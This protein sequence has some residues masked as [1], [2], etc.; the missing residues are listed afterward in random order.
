[1][2]ALFL[3]SL[4]GLAHGFSLSWPFTSF[5]GIEN[6]QSMPWLNLLSLAMM[7]YG[8]SNSSSVRQ[9]FVR[10]WTYATLMLL[11]TWWWLTISL[12]TY[13]GLA[14]VLTG[15]AVLI[16]A[17]GL[18]LIWASLLAFLARYAYFFQLNRW[19]QAIAFAAC[20]LL[21][22]IVRVYIFTGFPWGTSAY[23]FLDSP[24]SKS[25]P[26]I[27]VY[28]LSFW[29]ALCAALGMAGVMQLRWRQSSAPLS[30]EHGAWQPL[31]LIVIASSLLL[32]P[33][34]WTPTRFTQS[35]GWLSVNLLQ[36]NIAQ[37]LKFQENAGIPLALTWYR[38]QLIQNKADLVMAPETAIPVLPQRLPP[39]YFKEIR[40]HFETGA[41]K[42]Q[43]ALVGVPVG[44]S[45]TGYANS[46]MA[47][48]QSSI[49]AGQ[50]QLRSDK[51]V[52]DEIHDLYRYD[53]SHLV[54]FGEFVPRVLLPLT[55]SLQIPMSNFSGAQGLQ[56]TIDIHGQKIAPNI[57]YE[58]LFGEALAAWFFNPI[59]A[60]TVLANFSNIAWF[61]D[62][63]AI[64]QHLAIS[65]A[66]AIEFERSMI[67]ATNTGATAVIDHQGR[68]T[69]RLPRLTRGNLLSKVEGRQGVTPYAY[70]AARWDL[71]P[72]FIFASLCCLMLAFFGWRKSK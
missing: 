60:P 12:H 66:R 39:T 9:V 25:L 35:T 48:G 29:V 72:L 30:S 8:A 4:A 27:G 43:L 33:F 54:P 36:G 40:Q 22:E 31:S 70:W 3:L 51:A 41:G 16:L 20:W 1:M 64:E 11:S 21:S 42:G 10:A 50:L 55:E 32:L 45:G 61:G 47:F 26:W 69:D 56:G 15:L 18:G 58:D 53:K 44:S 14:P 38:E 65:R 49:L 63:V 52:P 7:F 23:A 68:V 24:L 62:T 13:G 34:F 37:D 57:C 5:L 59:Q 28:G 17:A 67:R 6:G 46:V 71:W 2:Q 19:Q